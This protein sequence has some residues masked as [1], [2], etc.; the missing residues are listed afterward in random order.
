M[1]SEEER[2]ERRAMHARLDE[3]ARRLME[4]E[5]EQPHGARIAP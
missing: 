5:P 1:P 3:I 2:A 4:P